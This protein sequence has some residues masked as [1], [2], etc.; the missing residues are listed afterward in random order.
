MKKLYLNYKLSDAIDDHRLQHT[1]SPN[2]IRNE[3]GYLLEE[4]IVEGLKTKGH[5]VKETGSNAI[6]QGIFI[7]KTNN[8][9]YAKSDKRKE[10]KA[11]GY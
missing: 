10:G 8:R 5:K 9:I 3:I 2:E 11:S 7:D 4:D 1:F 6:I